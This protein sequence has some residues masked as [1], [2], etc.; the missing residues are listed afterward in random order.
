MIIDL[1]I[2]TGEIFESI[3]CL[4]TLYTEEKK[5]PLNSVYSMQK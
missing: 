3:N 1:S 4:E 2:E 5:N